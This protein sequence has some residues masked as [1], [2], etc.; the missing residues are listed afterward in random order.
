[1]DNKQ[2]VVMSTNVQPHEIST[3]RRMQSDATVR[4]VTAPMSIV[5]YNKWM[6]GV[7]RGDQM[8]QYYH[9]CLKRR[10]FS[11]F[12]FWST[13]ASQTLTLYTKTS[14]HTCSPFKKIR[15]ELA[16]TLIGSYNSRKRAARTTVST[17]PRPPHPTYPLHFP[18]KKRK[19]SRKGVS[20]C[21][22]CAH[23]RTP[24]L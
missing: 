2:V 3:V 23:T 22:Y 12:G 9:L 18:V 5:S 11:Y 8:R 24:S 6:G 10:K 15:L 17:T 19:N 21:W 20:R 16:N 7:D 1:M 4:D 14:S 13:C